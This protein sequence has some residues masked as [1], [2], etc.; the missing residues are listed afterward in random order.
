MSLAQAVIAVVAKAGIQ[1]QS[2]QS[3]GILCVKGKLLDVR[4]AVERIEASAARKIVRQEI[5]DECR[6]LLIARR[7]ALAPGKELGIGYGASGLATF[8]VVATL[9][10]P[11]GSAERGG[12][13]AVVYTVAFLAFSLPAVAAGYAAAR[14]G[15]RT[16]VTVYALLVIAIG[17]AASAIG[18][19]RAARRHKPRPPRRD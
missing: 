17:V 13:F 9:A 5:G 10:G 11:A 2:S 16:T 14:V 15:L 19:V 18:E 12:L 7:P 8:G 6:I 3:D 4:I 1:C